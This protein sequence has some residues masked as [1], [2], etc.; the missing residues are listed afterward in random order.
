MIFWSVSYFKT[1]SDHSGL[2]FPLNPTNL[3]GMNNAEYHDLHHAPTGLHFNY[4][5]PF[6]TYLDRFFGT[7]KDPRESTSLPKRKKFE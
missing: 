3:P 2:K 7:Y 4:A 5:Q 1:V 6:F